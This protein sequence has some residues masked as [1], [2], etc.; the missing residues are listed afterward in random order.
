MQF[1][2]EPYQNMF[3][4]GGGFTVRQGFHFCLSV[5][6]AGASMTFEVVQFFLSYPNIKSLCYLSG[7]RMCCD[8]FLF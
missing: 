5:S 8:E 6:A 7:L 2:L 4:G 1:H 3:L